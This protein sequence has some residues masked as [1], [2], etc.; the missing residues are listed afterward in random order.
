[1][2]FVL[3][4]AKPAKN[5][6]TSMRGEGDGGNMTW[7][8]L[9]A[10]VRKEQHEE[11]EKESGCGAKALTAVSRVLKRKLTA[12]I[13]DLTKCMIY[14]SKCVPHKGSVKSPAGAQDTLIHSHPHTC[15]LTFG[16]A[17]RRITTSHICLACSSIAS[18]EL[19][20]IN[21]ATARAPNGRNRERPRE[22][23]REIL[24]ER[25][26]SGAAAVAGNCCHMT[27]DLASH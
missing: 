9:R 1:M 3:Q 22:R 2:K 12:R 13:F 24:Q 10:Q 11:E 14:D 7:Q 4:T 19:T 16:A 21:Y 17:S 15:T 25:C 6:S 20:R 5:L 18:Q 26:S 8:K 27:F 23:E